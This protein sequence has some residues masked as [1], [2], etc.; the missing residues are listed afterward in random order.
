[1][2]KDD[3]GLGAHYG[4]N[5]CVLCGKMNSRS[6]GISFQVERDGAVSTRFT[7]GDFLQGYADMLHGG[8]I[9]SLLDAAM[10]HCLFHQGIQAVTGDLRIRFV[11]PVPC[12]STL[13]IRARLVSSTPPLYRLR[14]EMA[15]DERI[16]AWAEARFMRRLRR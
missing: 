10:T 1:V 15:L 6:L 12:G 3:K 2:A 13:D 14:A 9:A 5:R 4:H 8:V 7:A 11:H 16:M